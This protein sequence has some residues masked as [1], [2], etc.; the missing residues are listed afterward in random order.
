MILPP[1][2]Q[3]RTPVRKLPPK[4]VVAQQGRWI[5][6]YESHPVRWQRWQNPSLD[7]ARSGEKLLAV[8]FGDVGCLA[9]RRSMREV[10]ADRA[11]AQQ[12]NERFVAILVDRS[13][14]PELATAYWSA[15]YAEDRGRIAPLIVIM[16][17]DLLPIAEIGGL[18]AEPALAELMRISTQWSVNR[19]PLLAVSRMLLARAYAHARAAPAIAELPAASMAIDRLLAGYD[20]EHPGFDTASPRFPQPARL[21]ALARLADRTGSTRTFERVEKALH[22]IARGGV[23]DQIGG[24]I[25]RASLDREYRIPLFE[26]FLVDQLFLADVSL[27]VW[28][29]TGRDEYLDLARSTLDF[30]VRDTQFER[31]G[32]APAYDAESLYA[33]GGQPKLLYG[34]YYVWKVEELERILGAA[35]GGR[36]AAAYGITR[37]GNIPKEL[38]ISGTLQGWSVP[39]N[40]A[41]LPTDAEFSRAAPIL[42]RTRLNR[43]APRSSLA[44]IA[45]STGLAMSVLARAARLLGE[46]RYLE[47]AAAAGRVFMRARVPSTR[48]WVRIPGSSIAA[49]VDDHALLACGYLDLYETSADIRWLDAAIE[50][51]T[52]LER[53]WDDSRGAYAVGESVPEAMRP[54][55]VEDVAGGITQSAAAAIALLRLGAATG[56]STWLARG[57]RIVNASG[58]AAANPQTPLAA[59]ALDL[60]QASVKA[61]QVF[62]LGSSGLPAAASLSAVVRGPYVELLYAHGKTALQQL[63]LRVPVAATLSLPADPNQVVAYVC[64]DGRCG[65]AITEPSL[66][67]ARLQ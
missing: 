6:D 12:L 51:M 62:I 22:A 32:F 63:A 66:L 43:P 23:R 42:L 26:K 20:D 50:S 18:A 1:P 55:V 31:G 10:L 28:Q 61:K 40:P 34:M 27:N 11:I 47:A 13:E 19:E 67:A 65:S 8:S 44:P 21:L 33:T 16:T 41:L 14:Y 48:T 25:H 56:N 17:P 30:V 37:A 64:H 3:A 38:D 59:I 45:S 58:P 15:F 46:P 9:C 54:L 24:G 49:T 35:V 29:V 53:R 57:A 36:I 4:A 60:V 5:S 7:R 52:Q 39:Q 2:A